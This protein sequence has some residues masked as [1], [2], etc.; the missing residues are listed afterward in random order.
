MSVE[1]ILSFLVPGE[2]LGLSGTEILKNEQEMVFLGYYVN[3]FTFSVINKAVTLKSS[4]FFP[5]QTLQLTESESELGWMRQAACC[6]VPF[7]TYSNGGHLAAQDNSFT[8][9]RI[10]SLGNENTTQ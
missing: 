3:A 9:G 6:E 2:C 8:L 7:Q 4:V 10:V 1:E 5:S